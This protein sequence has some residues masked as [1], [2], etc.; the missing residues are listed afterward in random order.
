M[1]RAHSRKLYKDCSTSIASTM[2]AEMEVAA[3][4]IEKMENTIARKEEEIAAL[5]KNLEENLKPHL[6]A[7]KV[8]IIF[9]AKVA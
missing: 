3:F 8:R 2:K 5:V 4:N 6:A 1:P 9:F 7:E